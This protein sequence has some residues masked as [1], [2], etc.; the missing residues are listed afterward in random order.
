MYHFTGKLTHPATEQTVLLELKLSMAE[1]FDSLVQGQP[2]DLKY[3]R[4]FNPDVAQICRQMTLSF[5]AKDPSAPI[6]HF[7]VATWLNLIRQIDLIH[8]AEESLD[9]GEFII[10]LVDAGRFQARYRELNATFNPNDLPF[11]LPI[12]ANSKGPL[13]K[14]S[15]HLRQDK[16]ATSTLSVL[17]FDPKSL[18]EMLAVFNQ[19]VVLLPKGY[20][21]EAGFYR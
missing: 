18:Q 13:A 11:I 3:Q 8:F 17:S 2:Y 4:S 14:M 16:R 9:S 7:I 20:E 6:N 10:S 12:L 1:L 15:D 19:M 21:L 5:K